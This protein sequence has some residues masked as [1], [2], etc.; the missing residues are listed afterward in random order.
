MATPEQ[1]EETEAV[2]FRRQ[3]ETCWQLFADDIIIQDMPSGGV[4]IRTLAMSQGK[5]NRAVRVGLGSE[6]HPS[7]FAPSSATQDLCLYLAKI[8]NRVAGTAA[9]AI[10]ETRM[11][12]VAHLYLDCPLSEYRGQGVHLALIRARLQDAQQLG[13]HLATA[14]TRVGSGSAR[15]VERSDMQLAY[16]TTVFTKDKS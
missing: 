13:V 14:I 4:A 2:H 5:L 10:L 12:K 11:G 15:N 7:P 16:T 3:A 6:I 8:N 9:L 1:C